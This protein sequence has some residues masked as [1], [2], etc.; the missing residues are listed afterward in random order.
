M[1]PQGLLQRREDY[2]EGIEVPAAAPCL[3]AG[4]DT[5][6]DRFELLVLGWGP[7]EERWIVDWRSVPGD[8]KHPET[9][10]RLLEALTR[11]YSSGS[12]AQLPI[13]AVCIDS[14]GHRT[15]A[16]YDF[17]LAHQHLRLYATIGRSGLMRI[18]AMFR[19]HISSRKETE[20]PS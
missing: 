10:A 14:G 20:K 4:V 19:D 8:P 11:K 2:G 3:T 13:H 1:E 7:G 15:D 5:Q 18:L 16:V 9:R 6:D 17:V 12:G